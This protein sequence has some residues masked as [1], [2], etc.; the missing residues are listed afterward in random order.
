MTGIN[1]QSIAIV[2][3]GKVGSA[4]AL[5]LSRKGY[6][7]TGVVTGQKPIPELLIKELEIPVTYRPEEITAMADVV[8]ITTPDRLITPVTLE[9]SAK[10]GFKAGQMVFHTSG[11]QPADDVGVVR[12]VG[13]FAASM[14]PLQ[15]FAHVSMAMEQLPGS[16]FALEGDELAVVVAEQIVADLGGHSFTIA[17]ADK[18]LYHAAACIASN[19]LVSLSHLATGLYGRFGLSPQEA[20]AA[21][22]P[23][24]QGTISNIRQLTPV[25]ALTGPVARGDV[26]TVARHLEALTQVGEQ[27]REVYRILARYTLLVAQEKGGFDPAQAA[28]LEDICKEAERK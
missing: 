13:A 10:G 26:T 14:H 1:K 8:F 4:L 15:S 22:L 11:S 21:L 16:Y 5:L 7:I 2:G 12:E 9:I 17:T 28:K 19:Y 6:N 27:E 18:P 25:Q 23:L 24:I 20:F 3:A